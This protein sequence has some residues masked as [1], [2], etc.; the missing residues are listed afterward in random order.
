M[1]HKPAISLHRAAKKYWCR[2]HTINVELDIHLFEEGLQ[3]D[4]EWPIDHYPECALIVM[5]AHVRDRLAEHRLAKRGHRNQEVMRK[6]RRES[7]DRFLRSTH[8]ED[9][10]L[11]GGR[12]LRLNKELICLVAKL[13]GFVQCAKTTKANRPPCGGLF[14]CN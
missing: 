7:L 10:T 2:S 9:S 14:G 12:P 11:T 6:V 5:L 13:R 3:L 1:K 8:E 4:I